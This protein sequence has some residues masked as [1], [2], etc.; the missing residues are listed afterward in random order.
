MK[1]EQSLNDQVHGLKQLL[2]ITGFPQIDYIIKFD[3]L[4]NNNVDDYIKA[5]H[6]QQIWRDYNHDLPLM[7]EKMKEFE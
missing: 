3:S 1:I 5:F 4:S 7:E 2:D 6:W